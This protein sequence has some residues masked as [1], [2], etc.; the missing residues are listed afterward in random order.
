MADLTEISGKLDELH[1][2]LEKKERLALIKE[3][4]I[5]IAGVL[6]AIMGYIANRD[7][8]IRQQR[9]AEAARQQKYL[10]YFLAHYSEASS[11]RQPRAASMRG[12]R[13]PR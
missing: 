12:I 6:L 9:E 7:A 13:K 8:N 10:E 5:P 4:L 11:V 1:D 3:I 2:K